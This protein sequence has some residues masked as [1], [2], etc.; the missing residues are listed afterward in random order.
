MY[1]HFS[2]FWIYVQA[3]RNSPAFS[4]PML[5]HFQKHYEKYFCSEII[6]WVLCLQHFISPSNSRDFESK[7]H[8][9]IPSFKYFKWMIFIERLVG[10]F[11]MGRPWH[12]YKFFTWSHLVLV[13]DNK[14]FHINR[15]TDNNPM[16]TYRK[17]KGN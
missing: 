12:F 1:H 11:W 5:L 7:L 2:K 8:P 10:I 3:R 15:N 4:T 14:C 6:T 17:W 13:H 16:K 9:G